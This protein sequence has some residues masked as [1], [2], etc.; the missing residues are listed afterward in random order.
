MRDFRDAKAIAH[1]LRSALQP[2]GVETTHSE[3]LEL[4]AKAFGFDSWNIL[5][6]KIEAAQSRV[7]D[8][9]PLAA[10]EARH[11]AP[12][13]ATLHCSFCGKSQHEVRALVA[14]PA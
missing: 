14:G 5:A 4:I 7:S 1:A 2:K 6:A 11:P 12:Q 8:A 10:A 9:P 3:C 13:K